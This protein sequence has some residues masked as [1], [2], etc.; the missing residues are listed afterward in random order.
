MTRPVFIRVVLIITCAVLL[1]GAAAPTPQRVVAVGDIHGDLDAFVGILQKARLIDPSRRW[2]GGNT[3][4]VQ[5]GDMLDRG[6][7][8][9]AVMDLLMSLQRD[10]ARQSGRGIVLM[11]NH[12]ARNIFGDLRY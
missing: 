1:L 6:P 11:G 7:Q 9:R 10:A 12:E 4:F 5:T 8:S 3:I 2:S